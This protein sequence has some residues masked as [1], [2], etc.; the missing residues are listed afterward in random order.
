M[1]FIRKAI[2]I[3]EFVLLMVI[4]VLSVFFSF[5]SPYFLT[6]GKWEAIAF[7][8]LSDCIIAVGMVVVIVGGGFD[9][10]VGATLA[11]CGIIVAKLLNA[12]IPIWLAISIGG[13][14]LGAGIGLFNGFLI[15]KAR[16]NPFVVTLGMMS[17]GRGTGLA[18]TQGRPLAGLPEAFDFIGQ[19]YIFGFPFAIALL[20][21]IIVVGDY[22]M[23][24][25]RWLRQ[26]YYV[27][28]NEEAARFS[29]IN[30]DRVRTASYVLIGILAGVA[31]VVTT[32]RMSSIMATAGLGTELRAIAAVVIGGGSLSGGKGSVFGAFLGTLLLGII[33]DILI[34]YRV[35]VYYQ[36]VV[37][38]AILILV[39]AIDTLSR[40]RKA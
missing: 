33:T 16:I 29:G 9:L 35:S 37:S 1:E 28:G 13:I 20:I 7:G 2:R 40:M 36:Q 10:S 25:T 11:L 3:R 14:L 24:Q 19:G 6:L 38:G 4:L 39:V 5:T 18:I 27:G 30:V 17:I 15:T 26:V 23:R 31:G 12:G 22:L 34:L 8:M 21:V 32:S